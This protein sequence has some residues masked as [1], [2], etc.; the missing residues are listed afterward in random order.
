M[1]SV[2]DTPSGSCLICCIV[3][4][5]LRSWILYLLECKT[6]SLN[7]AQICEVI[8]NSLMKRRT[9]PC[10]SRLL[11]TTSCRAKPWPALPNHHVRSPLLW[12]VMQH[13]EVTIPTFG[14]TCRSHLQG[15]RNLKERTEHDK[16]DRHNLL[17]RTCPSSNFLTKHSVLEASSVSVFRQRST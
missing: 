8:S 13:W 14:T 9:I 12:D 5:L 7:L 6:L 4:P 15:P 16:V 1:I 3:I 11:W 17:F 10:Q 2:L